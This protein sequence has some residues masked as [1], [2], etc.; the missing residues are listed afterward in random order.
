MSSIDT[1]INA[2]SSLIIVDGKKFF[3]H[4]HNYLKISKQIIIALSVIAFFVAGSGYLDTEII[5]NFA[6]I[7]VAASTL[8][9]L[10][11]IFLLR[12]EMKSLVD[13]YNNKT[14]D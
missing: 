12:G 10:I 8:P 14:N 13:T 9:N 7:T 5:W 3:R 6:L 1:L 2:I 11:S 4:N